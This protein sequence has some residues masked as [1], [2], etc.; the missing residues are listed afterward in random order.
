M[1]LLTEA[2]EISNIAFGF[3]GSKALFAALE[4]EVFSTLADAPKTS[5]ELA[6]AAEFA[7]ALFWKSTKMWMIP[8]W[9]TSRKQ[10]WRNPT[11]R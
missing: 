2:D 3:M 11:F 8:V 6:A 4:L 5:A 1:S 7:V 9:Q 10:V